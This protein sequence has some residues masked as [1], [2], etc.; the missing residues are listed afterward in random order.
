MFV[1]KS[2][3]GKNKTVGHPRPL[4][5]KAFGI[6]GNEGYIFWVAEIESQYLNSR[7]VYD[8]GYFWTDTIKDWN[9]SLSHDKCKE[10]IISSWQE[11]VNR[12]MIIVYGFVIMP[13][14]F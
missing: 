5:S 1:K 14:H 6:H 10:I 3:I 7:M 13:N 2:I 11:L 4:S 8:A 12:R 9:H